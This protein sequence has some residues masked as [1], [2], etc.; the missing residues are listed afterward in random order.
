[1]QNSFAIIWVARNKDRSGVSPKRFSK[2]QA[3]ALTEELNASHPEF[4][5]EVVDTAHQEVGEALITLKERTF[6]AART[7]DYSSFAASAAVEEEFVEEEPA[8]P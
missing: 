6:G 1:M 7:L 2:E 5:H 8:V 3:Q 4:H